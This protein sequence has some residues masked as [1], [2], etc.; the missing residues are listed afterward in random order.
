MRYHKILI[1][2]RSGSGKTAGLRNLNP[3]TTGIINAD[4]QELLFHQEKYQTVFD[5]ANKPDL[6]KSNYVETGKPASVITTLKIW[7]ER[8]D[9]D[10]VVLDTITHLITEYYITEALGKEYGGYKELGTSF[11]NIL[12]FVRSMK[13]NVI[14]FGHI[15]TKF[16]DEGMKE[17]TL[18]SHGK[19]I[20][21][22]ESESYFNVLLM[23]EVV[24]KDGS[25]AWIFRT[26][27]KEVVEKLKSPVRFLEDGTIERALEDDEPND[28]ALI[29]QKLNTFYTN[30]S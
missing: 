22:F 15:N 10:T 9:L 23:A 4:K 25:L 6:E 11:W 2:G 27:P 18:K 7:N 26:K 16:N 20:D 28:V 29:L 21:A 17:I 8:E 13:K 30:K 12:N 1:L 19:M 24:K 5:A 14:I 3:E